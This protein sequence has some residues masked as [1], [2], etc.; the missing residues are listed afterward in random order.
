MHMPYHKIFHCL[1]FIM[2]FVFLMMCPF[3]QAL[4]VGHVDLNCAEK[5]ITSKAFDISTSDSCCTLAAFPVLE[6]TPYT[7]RHPASDTTQVNQAASLLLL[8]TTKLVL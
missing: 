1:L 3:A 6:P 5:K 7:V 8:A 2:G 4:V